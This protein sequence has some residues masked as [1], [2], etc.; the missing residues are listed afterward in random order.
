M[1]RGSSVSATTGKAAAATDKGR[2]AGSYRTPS[3]SG[4]LP[5]RL[6]RMCNF[7]LRAEGLGEAYNSI[8][9]VRSWFLIPVDTVGRDTSK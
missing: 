7:L 1:G 2:K 8:K 3:G 5:N 9:E 4:G 6:W